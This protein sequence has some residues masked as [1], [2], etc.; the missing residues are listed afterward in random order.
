[1]TT[2]AHGPGG[3]GHARPQNPVLENKEPETRYRLHRR[4]DRLGRLLGDH[5]VESLMG[6][7][8]VVFGVGGVGSFAAEA[9]ARS[10]VGHLMLVDFDDVCITNSNRQLPAL[11]G[12]V[13]KPKVWLMRD[14]LRLINPPAHVESKRAFYNAARA[15][16]L[17]ALPPAWRKH[18]DDQYDFVVD[19]IDNLTAKA[20]L[21]A[22]CRRRGIPVVS[23]AG[24]AG[25][26][27]PTAIRIDDLADAK[28]CPLARELRS[29]LRKKHGFPTTG[30][31]GVRTVFSLEHRHWPKELTYDKGEGFSC[32]CPS[33][34]AEV[35]HVRDHHHSCDEKNLIDGT[36]AY[37]TG[38]FGLA[39]AS[40]VIN[41]L[42]DD[43]RRRA[44]DAQSNFEKK[45]GCAPAAA[46]TTATTAA[47][48]PAAATTMATIA[49]TTADEDPR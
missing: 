5:A 36:V 32:V 18:D 43:L 34:D 25:K 35:E 37:V 27:D 20:H 1:V 17:L 19:A 16:E 30:P 41:S 24:A 39:C 13:G 29:I 42:T 40:V 48:S 46:T 49:T 11:Q 28:V 14:R 21:L 12:N 38:A 9:L 4:F 45:A 7:R 33:G 26:L 44:P 47:T 8:V 10:A 15:D 22:E 23:S 6:K 31:L 2:H 3:H